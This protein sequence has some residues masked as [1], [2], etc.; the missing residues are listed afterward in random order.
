MSWPEI[1]FIALLFF[2]FSLL[3][4]LTRWPSV[5]IKSISQHSA[6]FKSSFLFFTTVQVV[7]GV[8]TYLF[9]IRWFIPQFHLPLL[10][11]ILYSLTAWLQII[12]A[13]I[14]DSGKSLNHRLHQYLA[15]PFAL[16]MLFILILL[17]L[18]TTIH[19]WPKLF[20]YISTAYIAGSVLAT[21]S[22]KGR[23]H[24][25]SN[26]L[27]LQLLYIISFQLTVLAITFYK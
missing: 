7:V 3:V 22:K 12:S 11:T 16:G 21:I 10:F 23:P 1:A 8:I 25:M 2:W 15:Y 17:C 18:T 13:F 6:S 4:L 20:T 5:R 14:P 24:V 9:I 19:G 26:Y 27:P